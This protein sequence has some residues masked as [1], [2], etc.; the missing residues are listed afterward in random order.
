MEGVKACIDPRGKLLLFEMD[1]TIETVHKG[2][3]PNR[4]LMGHHRPLFNLFLTFSN[5]STIK[6][7]NNPYSM[8]C[9]DSNSQPF[10]H[11]SYPIT[12]R[13]RLTPPLA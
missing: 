12:T 10:D 3:L 9:W 4:I 2:Q 6:Y 7:E 11:Q 1:K 13:P 5:S 8:R